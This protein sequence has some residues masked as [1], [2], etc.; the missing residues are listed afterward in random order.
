M[1]TTR[2]LRW[3]V[4]SVVLAALVAGG[5]LLASSLAPGAHAGGRTRVAAS[6]TPVEPTRSG[7][8]ATP[9][10]SPAPTPTP[11]PSVTAPGR[12]DPAP[13]PDRADALAGVLPGDVPRA[14][15]GDLV[16]VAGSSPAPGSGTPKR[17]R[18][19]VERGLPVNPDVFAAFVMATL[20]DARGWG[21]Q[22]AVTFERTGGDADIRVVLASAAT[23]DAMCAPLR[24]NGKWS[25]G[26]YGHAALNADRWVHGAEAFNEA[27]GGDLLAY[28]QYLVNHEV[29]HLLGHP[30]EHCPAAGAPAPVMVQQSI[31]LEGCRPNGWPY[32]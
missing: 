8:P 14:L 18:V 22:G 4:L 21:A 31:T 26:R 10:A 17:V 3:A 9:P 7:R 30:H 6:A 11:T 5:G 13:A 1:P 29:G 32:P 15:T 25:C 19:E 28:R 16:V 2:L 20:N 27:T 23:V 12:P 24:T